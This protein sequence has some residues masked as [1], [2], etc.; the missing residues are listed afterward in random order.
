MANLIAQLREHLLPSY[1]LA[2]V[3]HKTSLATALTAD[4]NAVSAN[5]SE[6]ADFVLDCSVQALKGHDNVGLSSRVSYYFPSQV[7]ASLNDVFRYADTLNPLLQYS[8][9]FV[10]EDLDES[11]EKSPFSQHLQRQEK[12]QGQRRG[13]RRS[14]YLRMDTVL[15]GHI[16]ASSLSTLLDYVAQD[17]GILLKYFRYT[18]LSMS[19]SEPDEQK[20]FRKCG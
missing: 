12:R 8:K 19:S 3:K 1:G 13:E 20:A 4:L 7:P 11:G 6:A 14:Y 17:I 16:N 5:I 2:D 9:V 15:A 18:T 10:V